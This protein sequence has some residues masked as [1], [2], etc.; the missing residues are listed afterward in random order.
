MQPPIT[1]NHDPQTDADWAAVLAL[2]AGGAVDPGVAATS[3]LLDLFLPLCRPPPAELPWVIG[4]VGQSL[5]GCIATAAGDSYYV[6]GPDNILHL[7]RL[8]AV[9]DAVIV[10]AGTVQTDNPR[11]TARLAPGKHPLRVVIDPARRLSADRHVF[12]D[13]VAPTLRVVRTG[14]AAGIA[15][16]VEELAIS[17]DAQ[18][19]DLRALLLALRER[20][21]QRV[22]VEGGGLTVAG[23]MRAGLMDRLHVAVAP[24]IIGQGKLALPLP[25]QEPLAAC[26]RPGTRVFGMGVD[27]LWDC[28]LRAAA[29]AVPTGLQRLR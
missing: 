8:R 29:E 10:G 26:L 18:G 3:A 14:C 22:F 9:C 28:D 21:C 13:A 23:F 1:P 4:H 19:L 2:A 16:D 17:G 27:V 7:H 12:T 5:D 15:V 6:T 25:G 11:L 20:G 24:L